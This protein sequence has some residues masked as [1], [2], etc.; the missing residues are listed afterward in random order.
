[1]SIPSGSTI[2]VET[3]QFTLT[4]AFSVL[5]LALNGPRTHTGVQTDRSLS[6]VAACH[7]LQQ[8]FAPSADIQEVA[9]NQFFLEI[10]FGFQFKY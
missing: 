4:F 8:S 5:I 1:M 6:L 7:H 9:C 3:I 10:F 2:L